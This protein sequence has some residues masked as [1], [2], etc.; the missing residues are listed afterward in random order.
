M[1]LSSPDRLSCIGRT[2]SLPG[3]RI[4]IS[5][6]ARG[7]FHQEPLLGIYGRRSSLMG[8]LRT[9]VFSRPT[10]YGSYHL[11]WIRN[12]FAELNRA[13]M[14]WIRLGEPH[15]PFQQ[16]D[17]GCRSPQSG[18]GQCPIVHFHAFRHQAITWLTRRSGLADAERQLIMGHAR[19]ERQR[20]G[21]HRKSA[22][23]GWLSRESKLLRVSHWA[24]VLPADTWQLA[25]PRKD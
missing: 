10:R 1:N 20:F 4:V 23:F 2:T 12:Y 24:S 8:L 9:E 17:N 25:F 11:P 15:R 13:S 19:C 7:W 3:N 14:S 22:A 6:K 16:A 5:G 18:E 21:S